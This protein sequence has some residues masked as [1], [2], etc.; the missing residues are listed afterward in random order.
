MLFMYMVSEETSKLNLAKIAQQYFYMHH[1][2]FLSTE[3]VHHYGFFTLKV[4][5]I[6]HSMGS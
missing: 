4:H 5:S 2:K 6:L 1:Y 3:Y